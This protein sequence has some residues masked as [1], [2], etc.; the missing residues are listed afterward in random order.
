M[1]SAMLSMPAVGGQL[2]VIMT[3]IILERQH[4]ADMHPTEQFIQLKVVYHYWYIDSGILHC[5]VKVACLLMKV[6]RCL[7]NKMFCVG[8]S[9]GGGLW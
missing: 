2:L 7:Q 8:L 3:M 4:T 5:S 6:V 1:V 9:G